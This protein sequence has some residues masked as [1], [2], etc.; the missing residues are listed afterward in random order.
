[1]RIILPL[2][3]ASLLAVAPSIAAKDVDV[4]FDHAA[5]FAKFKTFHILDGTIDAKA[6]ALNN[7]I[8]RKNLETGIRQHLKAK[9]L[10]EAEEG[11]ASD[12]NVRYHLG[13]AKHTDTTAVPAGRFGQRTRVIKSQSTEGTLTIDLLA[14]RDLVWRAIAVDDNKD[15]AKIAEHLDD[16]IKKAIGKYPPK[17]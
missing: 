1:M 4:E 6:P 8:V 2:I 10:I 7:N 14:K 15:P 9:G 12:L 16:M 5:Q 17:K 13:S 3:C 11:M